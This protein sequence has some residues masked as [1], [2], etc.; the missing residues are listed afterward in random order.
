[1]RLL[2]LIAALVWAGGALAQG[3]FT[4][5][6]EP[7]CT[8][9]QDAGAGCDDIRARDIVDAA[10]VPWRAIGRVNFA[11]TRQR[12]HCTGVLVSERHVL[13]AAHCLF[14]TARNRWIPA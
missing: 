8:L 5:I 13:T 7:V 14:N 1:M 9:G 4:D 3:R 6:W 12:S 2:F 11:S 10:Q